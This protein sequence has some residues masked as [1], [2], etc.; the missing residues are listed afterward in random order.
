MDKI[1]SFNT[2]LKKKK[3]EE[4]LDRYRNKIRSLRRSIQCSSCHLRCAMCGFR[5]Q[6]RDSTCRGLKATHGLLL[7][8][9]CSKEYEDFVS[10]QRDGKSSDIFWHNDE[11]LEMWSSWLRYRRALRAFTDS[12]E[13]KFLLRKDIDT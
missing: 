13:F 7:C 2:R 8:E 1:V 9:D 11:W 10:V 5:A 4:T 3:Q 12:P 6:T